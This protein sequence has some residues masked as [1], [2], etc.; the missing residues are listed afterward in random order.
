MLIA[1]ISSDNA[2]NVMIGP[3]AEALDLLK[4]QLIHFLR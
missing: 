3:L 1:Y 2:D 4:T